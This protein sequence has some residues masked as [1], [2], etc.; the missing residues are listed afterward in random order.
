MEYGYCVECGHSLEA[1]FFIEKEEKICGG[2]RILTG[3]V[4]KA[5][6]YLYCP[7]CGHKETVDDTF[8]EP[9]RYEK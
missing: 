7:I 4:R 3:R 2:V 9:W 5:V 1:V 6:D 8:D